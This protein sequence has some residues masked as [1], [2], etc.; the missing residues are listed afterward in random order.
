MPLWPGFPW[1]GLAVLALGATGLP[2]ALYFT[3]V[4]Y[5]VVPPDVGWVPRFCR[6]DEATC[7]RVI[8]TRHGHLFGLPN[9][10][11]GLGWYLLAAVAGAAG[12]TLGSF[13]LCPTLLLIA[14]A[15]VAVSVYLAW[16]LLFDLETRC[17]LCFIS[18]GLNAAILLA[19][20]A[21]CV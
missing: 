5:R 16:A 9:G 12:A 7:A 2:I 21:G 20:A 1:L 17:N 4:A 18:H 10:L 14:G 15:T 8:D 11:L 3:L 6:M 13:P 19:L